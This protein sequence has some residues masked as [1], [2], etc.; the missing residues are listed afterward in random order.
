MTNKK[1][2][3]GRCGELTVKEIF[4]KNLTIPDYQRAYTWSKKQV[5]QLVDDLL[6]AYKKD[7]IYLIGNMILHNSKGNYDIVDGQQRITTLALLLKVLGQDVNFLKNQISPLSV[8]SLQE[9]YQIL[10][11]R[12]ENYQK[13]AFL[14]F[15]KDKVKITYI[16]SDDL[17][18]AFVLFDSQNTR[19]E[20]LKRKDILKV[21]HIHPIKDERKI[22]AKKWEKWDKDS[23]Y[24]FNILDEVLYLVSLARRGVTGRLIADD[25]LDIDVFEEFKT[26]I[27]NKNFQKLNN[28][29]QPSL[30]QYFEFDFKNN[31]LML[32]TKPLQYQDEKIINEIKYVPFEINSAIVGGEKFFIFIYKYLNLYKELMQKEYFRD[33]NV[34]RKGNIYLKKFY[35]TV[36]LFYYDKFEDE[37]LKAFAK[38]VLLLIAYL[39]LKSSRIMRETVLHQE[40]NKEQKR[41]D[42]LNIFSLIRDSY[43]SYEI[44][45]EIDT[46]IMFNLKEIQ[47][48]ENDTYAKAKK[49]F[50]TIFENLFDSFEKTL[51]EI[52]D[53][54]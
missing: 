1:N 37:N 27:L 41:G 20:P 25:F 48:E 2:G 4:K 22:Y 5:E 6:E 12:F 26:K 33:I 44:L 31:S 16:V 30:Y 28:Y 36:I 51:K 54:K 11:N 42:R 35:Q 17:D 19:G 49:S 43:S 18:E 32:I 38:R 29:N 3:L 15:L 13:N 23:E 21:H 40:W 47:I 52:K 50:I 53:G 14:N 45:E 24:D 46:Y 9:N 39:R 8:N 10:Q 7:K 34:N